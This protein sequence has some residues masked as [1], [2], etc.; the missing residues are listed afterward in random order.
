MSSTVNVFVTAELLYNMTLKPSFSI[1]QFQSYTLFKL[2]Q[3]II[4]NMRFLV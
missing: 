3:K 1:E 2:V 4:F